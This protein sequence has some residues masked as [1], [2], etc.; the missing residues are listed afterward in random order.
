LMASQTLPARTGKGLPDAD[1]RK[2]A[3]PVQARP[4]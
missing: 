4:T 1:G 3:F 2:M